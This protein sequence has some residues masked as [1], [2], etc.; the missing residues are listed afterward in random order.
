MA[1]HT[2]QKGNNFSKNR[3][4]AILS[5]KLIEDRLQQLNFDWID[6]AIILYRDPK[7]KTAEQI[8][9][10]EMFARKI[11]PDQKAVEI[12]GELETT[13][14]PI[15]LSGL[16]VEELATLTKIAIEDEDDDTTEESDQG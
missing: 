13:N 3:S 8:R 7:C 10:I 1:K 6:E 5:K 15:D 9:I 2:F 14:K 16:S 11:A 4:Q 12:S